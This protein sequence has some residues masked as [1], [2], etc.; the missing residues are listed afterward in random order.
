MRKFVLVVSLIVIVVLI[1][2]CANEPKINSTIASPFS[3]E[4][5]ETFELK[6]KMLDAIESEEFYNIF[7]NSINIQKYL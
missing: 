7:N 5:M 1:S 3:S 2:G 4:Q 6:E